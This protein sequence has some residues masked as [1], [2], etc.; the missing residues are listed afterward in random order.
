MDN[1]NNI[2]LTVSIP[3]FVYAVSVRSVF[4]FMNYVFSSCM[5]ASSMIGLAERIVNITL[6]AAMHRS[7]GIDGVEEIDECYM[8]T[9][10][11]DTHIECNAENDLLH[12]GEGGR[13]SDVVEARVSPYSLLA[14]TRMLGSSQ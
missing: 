9:N 10:Y 1:P 6:S 5:N 14:F 13:T 8:N 3:E 11:G 2:A 12:G 4:Q 7:V